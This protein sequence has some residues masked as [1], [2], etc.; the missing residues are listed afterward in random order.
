MQVFFQFENMG[1]RKLT[2]IL[3]ISITATAL[4]NVTVSNGNYVNITPEGAA[5]VDAVFLF[6]NINEAELTTTLT[7]PKW[8]ALPDTLPGNELDYVNG[9]FFPEDGETYMVKGKYS[10]NEN[11]ERDTTIY[12]VTF[13]Y[14]SGTLRSVQIG[15]AAGICSETIGSQCHGAWTREI[16][17]ECKNVT[18]NIDGDFTDY[19]YDKPQGR[20]REVIERK[21]NIGYHTQAWKGTQ[22]ADTTI[23]EVLPYIDTQITVD[24]PLI[25]TEFWV[26]GDQFA[27]LLNVEKDSVY[28]D[29]YESV[30]IDCMPKMIVAERFVGERANEMQSPDSLNI[31]T[32]ASGPIEIEFLANPSHNVEYFHWEIWYKESSCDSTRLAIR[33]DE[34]HRYTFNRAGEETKGQYIITCMVSNN[35]CDSVVKTLEVFVNTSDLQI[36]NV[37]TPNGDGT[38]DEFRVAYKSLVEFQCV[39][40]NRWGRKIYEWSDPTK[41]WDGTINGKD[42]APGTY[43]YIIKARGADGKKWKRSGDINLIGR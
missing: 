8:F 3:L 20:G 30:A 24:A 7:S 32:G 14:K 19:T 9:A 33:T 23:S 26:T 36:P 29:T 4:A 34:N 1:F 42:A 38:N 39:I 12:V 13:A 40:F 17:C 22:W 5:G 31:S 10:N 27:Q 2:I 6:A 41:G 43:F 28:T 25:D 37:F 21:Y 15:T 11:Q 18:L 35:S 16:P